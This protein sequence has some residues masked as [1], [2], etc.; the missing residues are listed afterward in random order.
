MRKK[1]HK[2]LTWE[3]YIMKRKNSSDNSDFIENAI[4]ALQC[5]LPTVFARKEVPKLL[6]NTI[7]AGTLANFASEGY[8]PPCIRNGRNAI[9][10]RESFLNWFC[11]YLEGG[12]QRIKAQKD[13][14]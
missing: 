13:K 12:T 3:V 11:M 10:E 14:A 4:L 1:T 7:S 9:Y 8:G 2:N 6:G 5:T